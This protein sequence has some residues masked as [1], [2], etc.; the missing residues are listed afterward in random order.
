MA[1]QVQLRRSYDLAR[2][3]LRPRYLGAF[4]LAKPDLPRGMEQRSL[5]V[6]LPAER[7]QLV[8]VIFDARMVLPARS[9]W[10]LGRSGYRLDAAFVV[11]P[12]SFRR[13]RS[14]AA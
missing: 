6:H 12:A 2:T 4:F 14:H 5:S 8:L 10:L 3:P 11:S 9:R 1:R 7:G 13:I